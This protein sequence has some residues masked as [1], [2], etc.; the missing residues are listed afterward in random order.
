[1]DGTLNIHYGLNICAFHWVLKIHRGIKIQG[2][3]LMYKLI[4]TYNL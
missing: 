4:N 1:M 2:F 3:T